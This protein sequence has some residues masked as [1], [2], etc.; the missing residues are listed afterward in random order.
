[1]PS[2]TKEPSPAYQMY[3]KEWLACSDVMIMEPHQEG[4]YIRLINY[5]WVNDGVLDNLRVLSQLSRIP[6]SDLDIVIA[7][8]QPHPK[9]PG[10]LSHPRVQK[11]RNKQANFKKEKSKAGKAGAKKRWQ[12]KP[13]VIE[14]K[15]DK[16]D[17]TAIAH[18]MAN[19]SS[20]SPSPSPSPNKS[21]S[22]NTITC[23]KL[24]E[25][26]R[27]HAPSMPKPL[28]KMQAKRKKELLAR[29]KDLDEDETAWIEFC[30][31]IEASDFVTS[32]KADQTF[33]PGLDWVL[34][35][36]FFTKIMEGNYDN[37]TDARYTSTGDDLESLNF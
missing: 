9:K 37:D 10:Y 14:A 26:F 30:K 31:K 7:K 15:S 5:D 13:Q 29:F 28:N 34:K 16:Q 36:E 1:M 21:N 33:R 8:F 19:D 27:E 11:E 23:N 22:I 25:L 20:P 24:I 35:P 2:K 4:A 18:P 17:S 6:E 3:A 12:K 32:R